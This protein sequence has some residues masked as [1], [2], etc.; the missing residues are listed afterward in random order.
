LLQ[1]EHTGLL[2]AAVR[3]RTK[4][5]VTALVTREGV[6]P[7]QFWTLVAISENENLS[8]GELA[9]RQRM[10]EPTACRVVGA[11]SRRRLV[12]N[13]FDPA[14]RR[15]SRLVLTPSGRALV[16]KLLPIATEIREAIESSLTSAEREIV[17]SSLRKIIDSLDRLEERKSSET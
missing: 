4:R 8:L 16:R 14:D 7:Q 5:L 11:L 12:R 17:A 9:R 3:R 1:Q 15:R 10:D 13:G 6:S 2:I